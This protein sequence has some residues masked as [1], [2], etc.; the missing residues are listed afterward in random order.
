MQFSAVTF[1]CGEQAPDVQPGGDRSVT[2]NPIYELFYCF[3]FPA[4]TENECYLIVKGWDEAP[5]CL[6]QHMGY[7][8]DW[9]VIQ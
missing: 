6:C 8:G 1:I 4:V 3:I 5:V 7:T 2:R 9:L